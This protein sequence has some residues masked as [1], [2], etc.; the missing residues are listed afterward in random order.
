MS[1]RTATR[2]CIPRVMVVEWRQHRQ[3]LRRRPDAAR[4]SRQLRWQRRYARPDRAGRAE[5][6][7]RAGAGRRHARRRRED[8]DLRHRHDE[9]F[10]HQD[11]RMRY[12]AQALP[13]STTCRWRGCRAAGVHG[14]DRGVC[15]RL[16]AVRRGGASNQRATSRPSPRASRRPRNRRAA[17]GRASRPSRYI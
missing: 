8:H 10:R 5:H 13:T 11:V 16:S 2:S 15:D 7:G 9:H 12:F 1:G 4:L 17:A 3:T 6:Q 14:R